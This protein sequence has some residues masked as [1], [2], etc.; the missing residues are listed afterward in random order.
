[1]VTPSF[2]NLRAGEYYQLLA[3]SD[4]GA[5]TNTA[6]AAARHWLSIL[7][8]LKPDNGG[9]NVDQLAEE[10]LACLTRWQELATIV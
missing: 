8:R 1:M 7:P 9:F 5:W 4:L 3:S 2:N 6:A 10:I